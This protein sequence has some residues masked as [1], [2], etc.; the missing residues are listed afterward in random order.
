MLA[1]GLEE[2]S[3]GLS[4]AAGSPKVEVKETVERIKECLQRERFYT[5]PL[6]K[7]L[8]LCMESK[9]QDEVATYLAGLPEMQRSAQSALQVIERLKVCRGLV[10]TIVA[11]GIAITPEE[12][13]E[14]IQG[15]STGTFSEAYAM[16]TTSDAG[17]VV[18]DELSIANRLQLILEQHPQ[19]LDA[20][21]R[22]LKVCA[23]PQ[24]LSDI[25]DQLKQL[26]YK[27]S[28]NK[29]G[30]CLYPSFILD[31]LNQAGFLLWDSGWMISNEGKEALTLL[32][33]Y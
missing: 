32:Q 1:T 22:V 19:Y 2:D 29:S 33:E 18:V 31:F 5:E 17:R 21:T 15:G 6:R 10:T 14:T 12:Y 8:V 20:F 25:D 26:G 27:T 4:D 9:R 16:L 28:A 24:T 3:Q 11:D 30:E 23:K 13:E 7:V